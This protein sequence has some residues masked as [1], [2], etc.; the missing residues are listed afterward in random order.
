MK[1]KYT[2]L[3]LICSFI[4]SAQ[5]QSGL[6]KLAPIVLNQLNAFTQ[7][8]NSQ[9]YS[10]S[11]ILEKSF[12]SKNFLK[13]LKID[14]KAQIPLERD[15]SSSNHSSTIFLDPSL[16][17][18][19][20]DMYMLTVFNAEDDLF[21]DDIYIYSITSDGPIPRAKT[22]SIYKNLASGDSTLLSPE[23]RR[24]FPLVDIHLI[25]QNDLIVDYTLIESDGDDTEEL[26]K[27]IDVLFPLVLAAY[28]SLKTTNPNIIL[29]L[30]Q[31]LK[32]IAKYL[33][34]L[35]NDDRHFTK[36]LYISNSDL[37]QLVDIRHKVYIHR[38]HGHHWGSKWD[39]QL[40]FRAS[41]HSR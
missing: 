26:K 23:D 6:S 7:P 40:K 28:Q 21:G 27:L 29:S 24:L 2:F 8:G 19:T 22:T 35:N 13:G 16:H 30:H 10:S 17:S 39:Y 14:V 36:T 20:L 25:P 1:L 4:Q 34:E 32:A 38:K 31:E 37:L 5:P 3:F 33:L 41:I 12:I 11:L 15:R 9:Y 18:I